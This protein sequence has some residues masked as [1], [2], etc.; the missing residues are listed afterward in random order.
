LIDMENCTQGGE[1]L[2]VRSNR[3]RGIIPWFSLPCCLC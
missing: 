2:Y 1:N 3:L